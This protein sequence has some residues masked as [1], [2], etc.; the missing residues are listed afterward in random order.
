M[1][2]QSII[3]IG[4]A[5]LLG[6]LAVFLVNLYLTR[7]DDTSSA[8]AAPAGLTQVAVARVPLEFGAEINSQNIRFVDWP[9]DSVPPGAFGSMD[10]FTT[11]GVAPVVIRPVEIGEPILRS[12]LAGEGGRATL[13]ALLPADMR[14]ISINITPVLGVSGFVL[15]G[16]RVDIFLTHA[17]GEEQVTDVLLQNVPVIAIDQMASENSDEPALGSTATLEVSREDAQKLALA[18]QSG[19]LSLALRSVRA[20]EEFSYATA[21]RASELTS[22]FRY[23]PASPAYTRPLRRAAASQARPNTSGV[24]VVRGTTGTEY[25]VRPYRGN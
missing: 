12:R 9:A 4:V 20:E 22:G 17:E 11:N 7:A 24:E 23:S 2:R 18:R 21:L 10:E 5:A 6:L 3:V 19:T 13:S 15:P 1:R 25:Q 14:A 16:D 8:D